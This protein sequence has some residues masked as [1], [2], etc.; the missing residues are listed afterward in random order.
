LITHDRWYDPNP[1]F[2][3]CYQ[4]DVIT[5]IP[6]SIFP[7][8]DP[9]GRQDVWPL[10]RPTNLRDRTIQQAMNTLPTTLVGRAAKDV[11]DR[12]SFS[13]GEYI[14]AACRKMNVMLIPRSCALDNPKRKHFLVAPVIAVDAL[15]DAQRQ[16]D[17]L[18]ELRQNA[19]PQSFYLPPVGDLKESYADLLRMGPIHRTFFPPETLEGVLLARLSSVGTANLQ[20]SLSRHFGMQFGF[21]YKDICPQSGRYSCSNCFHAGMSLQ[22]RTFDNGAAF[23]PCPGC[24]EDAAWIK[25]PT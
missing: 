19:I 14:L 10:L 21:D 13:E 8:I 18:I 25:L 22:T 20:A 16:S 17:K 1:D 7:S 15:P 12:W 11:T 6:Y 9:A 23:G 2:T 24:G 4:G 5:D 3:A